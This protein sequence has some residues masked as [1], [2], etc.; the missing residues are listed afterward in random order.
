M[1]YF[2]G[3]NTNTFP[4]LQEIPVYLLSFLKSQ[5]CTKIFVIILWQVCLGDNTG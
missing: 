2:V 5:G 3:L 1:M 4:P